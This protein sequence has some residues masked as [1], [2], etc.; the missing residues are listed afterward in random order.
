ML[1]VLCLLGCSKDK[2]KLV[3]GQWYNQS[4]EVKYNFADGKF[5]SIFAVPAGHWEEMLEIK[6]IN[7]TFFEGG[8]YT[9]EYISLEG[10]PI[11]TTEGVWKM[12]GDTLYLTSDGIKTG[13]YFDWMDGKAA[14]VGL[15]DWDSDG[16]ADDLYSGVQI[17]RK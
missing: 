3:Q 6:P 9:S 5:D 4:I 17:K 10:Q 16:D 2:T 14:F 15:L 7:T 13:Y 12:E 11:Q 8:R 1:A